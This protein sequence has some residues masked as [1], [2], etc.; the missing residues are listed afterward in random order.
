MLAGGGAGAV[1]RVGGVG[2][3]GGGGPAGGEWVHRRSAARGE[4]N[5]KLEELSLSK[6][7][8][9]SCSGTAMVLLR[10]VF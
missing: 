3:A 1:L 8:N 6:M 4:H 9:R 7:L 5:S 10:L 2:A